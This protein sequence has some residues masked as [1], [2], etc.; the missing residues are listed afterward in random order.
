MDGLVTNVSLIAGVGGGGATR[1]FVVLSGFAGLVA[2]AFSMATGEFT[3]V[4]SQNELVDAE[5]RVEREALETYPDEEGRELAASLTQK[6]VSADLARQV[7]DQISATPE[8]ALQFHAQV[9]LGVDP[10]A[11]PSPYEAAGISFVSFAIGALIPLAPYLFGDAMLWLSCALAAA[12]VVIGGAVVARL[13]A[14]PL[15]RGILRQLGLA[16]IAVGVTYGIGR[17][18]GSRIG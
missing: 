14:R 1:H 3:S 4:R 5:V 11:L 13:T 2:G 9:E 6:G 10:D 15:A 18:I 8:H 12:A 7:S 17:A 16:A